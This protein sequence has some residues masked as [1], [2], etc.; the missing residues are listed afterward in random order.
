MGILTASLWCGYEYVVVSALVGQKGVD[1][2]CPI[3]NGSTVSPSTKHLSARED[4]RV[5][6]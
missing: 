6:V 3:S 1:N 5:G 4:L 2:A